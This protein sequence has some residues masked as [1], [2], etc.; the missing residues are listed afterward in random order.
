VT[1]D[2]AKA[3]EAAGTLPT[4]DP[5]EGAAASHERSED[6]AKA[7]AEDDGVPP[8]A[9]LAVV[10]NDKMTAEVRAAEA[11][12]AGESLEG[13][14]GACPLCVTGTVVETP[15]AASLGGIVLAC[16][17]CGLI[18][19]DV[20]DLLRMRDTIRARSPRGWKGDTLVTDA[21]GEV[22]MV[23]EAVVE[24][25]CFTHPLVVDGV[26]STALVVSA[27]QYYLA[28]ADAVLAGAARVA[29]LARE[30]AAF[31]VEHFDGP[32]KAVVVAATEGQKKKYLDVVTSQKPEPTRLQ[33]KHYKAKL[34]VDD[35]EAALAWAKERVAEWRA[36]PEPETCE[37]ADLLG[38]AV[39]TVPEAVVTT[40]AYEQ[41]DVNA[42][43][44][45]WKENAFIATGGPNPPLDYSSIPAGCTVQDAD[46]VLTIK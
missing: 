11:R 45:W 26:Q 44:T 9:P 46:D 34:K 22:A 30:K 3:R 7:E 28:T 25:A 6:V 37:T 40:P 2:E 5:T 24:G 8:E 31:L 21:K 12:Q 20:A 1:E 39:V 14:H 32:M 43:K 16:N 29:A 19:E 13:T 35:K 17:V 38:A 33:L 36:E 15:V 4:G 42:L 18:Y 10:S 27:I 41:L 23:N